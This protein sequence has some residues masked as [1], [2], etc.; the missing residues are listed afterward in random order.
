MNLNNPRP[1]GAGAS[2]FLCLLLVPLGARSAD[3]IESVEKAATEWV[4]TRAETTRL[5]SD[6]ASQRPLLE[7]MSSALAERA[8]AAEDKRDQLKA[9]TAKDRDEIEAAEAKNRELDTGLKATET[10]LNSLKEQLIRLRPSLPPRLSDALEL[11]FRS[12]AGP[13]QGPSERMQ[14][15]MT[16]LNRCVQFNRLVTCDEEVLTIDGESGPR[17]FEVVYWGLSH[18]Y[19]LDRTAMKVW[20][21]SPGPKGWQWE[22]RPEAAHS[23]MEL[24][25]VCKD[26]AEPEFVPVPARLLHSSSAQANNK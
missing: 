15:T 25:A 10:R 1:A 8:R 18:G 20:L 13:D 3:S 5:E 19:A 12:L 26:K 2:L 6:W 14:A 21:G 17:S 11:A 24:I 7:S 23:V 4:R 22:P 16:V 9:Q